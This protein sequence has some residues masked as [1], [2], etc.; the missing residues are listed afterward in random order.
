MNPNRSRQEKDGWLR[1]TLR[2]RSVSQALFVFTLTRGLVFAI[3][4]LVGQFTTET[5][6]TE[7]PNYPLAVQEATITL[8][9]RPIGRLL[10]EV[11]SKGDTDI[12]ITLASTGYERHSIDITNRASHFYAFFPLYPLVLYALSWITSDLIIAGTI[13]SNLLF[14]SALIIL[15]KL[16]NALGY[17]A[18]IADRSLFYL[19]AY[20]TSYFFSLPMT[21]SL[22]LFLTVASFFAATRDRWL[23]A[24]ILG[25]LCAVTRSNGIF[26]LP[27]LLL[28]YWQR[29]QFTGLLRKAPAIFLVPLGLVAY[30]IF[31]WRMTGIPWAFMSAQ[32]SWGRRFGFFLMPLIE[33]LG[34]PYDIAFPWNFLLLNFAAALLSIWAV[35]VLARR[36][37][38]ALSVFQFLL[39]LMPL[40]TLTLQSMARYS[41]LFFPVFIVLAVSTKPDSRLDQSIRFA[42][43]ALLALMTALFASY[44]TFAVA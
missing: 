6:T 21:E 25:A 38:W 4:I 5:I 37:D 19:A 43:V 11:I 20:P 13:L 40:S 18:D 23:C 26:L 22:A 33:Y 10:R 9:N 44:V 3:L 35:Y 14:L 12:Y 39:I 42:F 8:K 29:H 2:D 36:R 30:M 34:R 41:S 17:G 15:H 16:V 24:G 31:C 27:A 1:R 28:L 7:N 32:A